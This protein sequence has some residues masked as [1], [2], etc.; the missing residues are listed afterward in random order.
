MYKCLFIIF[1]NFKI[2]LCIYFVH[3]NVLCSWTLLTLIFHSAYSLSFINSFY[4]HLT[5]FLYRN[6]WKYRR[7]NLLLHIHWREN[8]QHSTV[9][10][11][12]A[13][14]ARLLSE[15]STDSTSGEMAIK[16]TYRLLFIPASFHVVTE[17]PYQR[18]IT[19]KRLITDFCNYVF[20]SISYL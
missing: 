15:S 5:Y 19:R 8:I 14:L 2:R 9:S 3:F 20:F 11:V 18:F 10:F 12:K 4:R 16:Y 6:L 7:L 17:F 13:S 1:R